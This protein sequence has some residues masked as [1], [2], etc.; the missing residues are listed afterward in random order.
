MFFRQVDPDRIN[1]SSL[2]Y[3]NYALGSYK[4]VRELVEDL[5]N[6]HISRKDY[7]G[8]SAISPDFHFYFVD[9]LGDSIVIEPEHQRL[10][11]F[12]NRY[13]VMT[14][15]PALSHHAKILEKTFLKNGREFH[16]AKDLPG[17]YDP[18]SRFVKAYYLNENIA[19]AHTQ[20]DAL[21]NTYSILEALK[22]PE[23]FTKTKGLYLPAT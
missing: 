12:A 9:A 5:P 1:L 7:Q 21:E 14:N 2:Y 10:K 20:Q 11:A 22:I 6:I 19:T 17:G 18:I 8:N 4:T 16:P 3:F 15:S 13:N 23:A